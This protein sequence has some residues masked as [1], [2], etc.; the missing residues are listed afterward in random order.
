MIGDAEELSR[1][2][3]SGRFNRL[4]LATILRA[5]FDVMPEDWIA[6]RRKEMQEY[7]FDAEGSLGGWP[8]EILDQG[9]I[10]LHIDI[11]TGK[12]KPEIYLG[13]ARIEEPWQLPAAMKY[14]DWN[15]CPPAEVHCAFHRQWHERFGAEITGMSGDVVECIVSRPPTDREAATALAW[16]Q[17]WYCADIV[18]QGVGTIADLAATLLN[19]PYWFFWWD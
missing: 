4:D 8:D 15:D 16:E 17:Y 2:E 5:S 18:E 3:E 6:N 1:V 7:G 9:S 14:G 10:M 13:F 19:S 11:M 12:T